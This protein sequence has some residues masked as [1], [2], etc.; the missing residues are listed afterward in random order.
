LAYS[1][2]VAEVVFVALHALVA[3]GR[4]K[5]SMVIQAVPGPVAAV[6]IRTSSIYGIST[7]G[8]AGKIGEGTILQRVTDTLSALVGIITLGIEQTI[9]TD[10]SS[11]KAA[12]ILR[13]SCCLAVGRQGWLAIFAVLTEAAIASRSTV[14]GI[15]PLFPQ[16][17]VIS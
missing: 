14:D 11:G 7:G 9:D 4:A 8:A 2:S 5:G 17:D 15:A 12:L 3:A 10:T 16:D 1:G 6:G 13:A